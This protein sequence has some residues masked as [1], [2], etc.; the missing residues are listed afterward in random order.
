MCQQWQEGGFYLVAGGVT[1]PLYLEEHHER[2][3][4][5]KDVCAA[6]KAVA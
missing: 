4:F 5:W 6:G 1:E 3:V 2:M